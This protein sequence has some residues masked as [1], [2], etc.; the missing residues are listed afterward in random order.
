M[1]GYT[2]KRVARSF[3]SVLMCTTLICAMVPQVARAEE[4]LETLENAAIEAN[5]KYAQAQQELDNLNQKVETNQSKLK[6]LEDALPQ[7][8]QNTAQAVRLN[9]KLLQNQPNLI[10]LILSSHDFSDFLSTISYINAINDSNYEKIQALVQME[11]QLTQTRNALQTQQ[12]S[13]AA[14]TKEAAAAQ[15]A[16]QEAI[17]VAKQRAMERAAQA[18]A[19]WEA[20]QAA[21]AQSAAATAATSTQ[22]SSSTN[23][24]SNSSNNSSSSGSASN[25]TD[26]TPSTSASTASSDWKSVVASVYGN[27]DGFMWGTTASGDIVTPT[28]MGVAMKRPMPLGTTIEIS[29]NGRTVRAV[30][31]DRGPFVAGREI[32]LQPAVASALGFDGVGTV[33]YRVV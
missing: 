5:E 19:Q 30:V 11:S 6:E 15:S 7:V 28:S 32:D 31:N 1:K 23:A 17:K 25:S 13:V 27:D 10:G 33:S 3:F 12:S 18:K 26:P 29:Y 20:Q 24:S 4:S 2:S 8:R 16:A 21:A 9:Y 22:N 14:K